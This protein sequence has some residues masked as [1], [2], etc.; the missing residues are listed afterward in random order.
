MAIPA[1]PDTKGRSEH[2]SPAAAGG[3]DHVAVGDP[4]VVGDTAAFE[5]VDGGGFEGHRIKSAV[6]TAVVGPFTYEQRR[7]RAHTRFLSA[8]RALAVVRRLA[9]P[10]RRPHIDFGG[11]LAGVV[12]VSRN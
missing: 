4:A 5:L 7:D 3:D 10:V 8:V 2:R 12:A 9:V 1:S 6:L 11:R